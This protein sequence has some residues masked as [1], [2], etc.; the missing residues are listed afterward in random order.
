MNYQLIR[1]LTQHR[2]HRIM[3][4]L[5]SREDASTYGDFMKDFSAQKFDDL[6]YHLG[7]LVKK[8]VLVKDRCPKRNRFCWYVD[9]NTEGLQ[10]ALQSVFGRV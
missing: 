8:N 6:S 9:P 2:R 10:E 3:V 7:E 4:S 1:T 5:L